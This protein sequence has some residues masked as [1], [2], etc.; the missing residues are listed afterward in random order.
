VKRLIVNADDLG[1]CRATNLAIAAAHRHG[2]LTS[3]SLMVNMPAVGHAVDEILGHHPRLGVGLHLC[4]TSGRPILR[5]HRV[6]LLV[7]MWG[8]FR[9]SFVSLLRLLRSRRGGDAR[10]QIADELWAQA[11]CARRLG[12]AVDHVNG[13]QH[14]HMLPGV[15]ETAADI[16][17]SFPAAL[18][19]PDSPLADSQRRW[20]EWLLGCT[21]GGLLKKAILSRLAKEAAPHIRDAVR[22]DHCQGVMETG[23]LTKSRLLALLAALPEGTTEIFT[24]PSG[25]AA[26]GDEVACS[27]ADRHFLQSRMRGAELAALVDPALRELATRYGIELVTFRDLGGLGIREWGSTHPTI[28]GKPH[29][30]SPNLPIS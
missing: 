3:A 14:V 10:R 6:P 21:S 7:D 8:D 29:H 22:A 25:S 12:V 15:I 17:A 13:H 19:V 27:A 20:P 2:I 5:P 26:A 30:Q 18:R 1:I 23:R 11:D 16:A 4:L 28:V 9:H 24:H